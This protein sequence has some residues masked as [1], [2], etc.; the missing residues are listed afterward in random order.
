VIAYASR[1]GTKRNL[2]VLR[3]AG[4]RLMISATGVWRTEGFTYAIDNGAWTAYQR[5]AAFDARAFSGL[6]DRLGPGADWIVVPDIV[7]AGRKSLEF[8]LTWL[9]QLRGIAPLLIAVQDGMAQADIADLVGPGTGIFIGGLDDFKEQT[10]AQWG[11]LARESLCYL[12]M[13][14]VNSARR[15]KIAQ[16]AGCDSFDG[17]SVSRFAVTLAPLDAARRQRMLI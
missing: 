12:H 4:W 14:R 10:A 7:G 9:P 17:S 1:T 3:R 15:I 8:S 2:D 6:V 13:G 5:G 16:S 11:V